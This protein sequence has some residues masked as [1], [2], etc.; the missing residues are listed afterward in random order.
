M[1][2]ERLIDIE[3]KIT[4]QEDQLEELNKTVYQQQLKIERLEAICEALANELRGLAEAGSDG[5]SAA[6]ERPPHY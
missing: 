2:E 6:N 5:R 3:A 1:N 4:F